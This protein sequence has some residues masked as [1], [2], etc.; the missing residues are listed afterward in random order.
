MAHQFDALAPFGM[1]GIDPVG[2]QPHHHHQQHHHDRS[3]SEAAINMLT[4]PPSDVHIERRIT[5]TRPINRYPDHPKIIPLCFR[6]WLHRKPKSYPTSWPFR[7]RQLVK[8]K[9]PRPN[10]SR[11]GHGHHGQPTTQR[12]MGGMEMARSH[13]NKY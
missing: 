9:A 12:G 3:I 2:D 11:S 13:F 1:I 10:P 7:Q 4:S 8:T 6:L 5:T